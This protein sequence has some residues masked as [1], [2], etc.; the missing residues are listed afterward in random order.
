MDY[1]TQADRLKAQVCHLRAIISRKDSELFL[2]TQNEKLYYS[3][4]DKLRNANTTLRETLREKSQGNS[5]M[6]TQQNRR[7]QRE[8][9]DKD[10]KM[11]ELITELRKKD[12][13]IYDLQ[14]NVE[15]L[16]E[17]NRQAEE[18]IAAEWNRM[19]EERETMKRSSLPASSSAC[20]VDANV[21]DMIN[22]N[23]NN[24]S[25]AEE[26]AVDIIDVLAQRVAMAE[27]RAEAAEKKL[28]KTNHMKDVVCAAVLDC[29]S[30]ERAKSAALSQLVFQDNLHTGFE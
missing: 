29:L 27:S 16:T 19:M 1:K 26:N 4:L 20:D 21:N 2:A 22:S 5:E 17:A 10:A 18:C 15:I 28:A 13:K 30:N 9:R 6:M 11:A 23:Q 7:L 25:P 12:T 24:L 8:L 14:I 3:E